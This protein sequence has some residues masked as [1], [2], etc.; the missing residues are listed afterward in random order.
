MIGLETVAAFF[1][2]A[3][4][5]TGLR[6]LRDYNP[7][8]R[9]LA[10]LLPWQFL[11]SSEPGVVL[12]KTGSF[13]ACFRLHG[14]DRASSTDGELNRLTEAASLAF[15]S[16]EPDSYTFHFD[17][18]RRPAGA[19]PGLGDFPDPLSAFL[20]SR[21]RDAYLSTGALYVTDNTL[22]VTY[23]PPPEVYQHILLRLQQ[24]V[25]RRNI[26]WRNTLE[27]FETDLEVFASK[28]GSAL[29][30]RRLTGPEMISHF[31][32]CVTGRHQVVADP[33]PGV[34]L[35][36]V[37]ATNATGGWEPVVGDQQLAL[38]SFFHLPGRAHPA[39]LDKLSDTPFPYRLS[40]RFTP[41][42][43]HTAGKIISAYTRGWSWMQKSPST[44][45]RKDSDRPD[46][47]YV[48]RHAQD[49]LQDAA[50]AV[51]ANT[52]AE[53]RFCLFTATLVLAAATRQLVDERAIALGKI[54]TDS[55]FTLRKETYNAVAAYHGTLPGEDVANSRA[56]IV[57]AQ[58]LADILPL[59]SLWPGPD[60]HPCSFF[61][62]DSPPI[63]IARTEGST[64]FR[65]FLHSGDLGHTIIV[66]P[67]GAGKST[68]LGA[69]CLGWLRYPGSRVYFFDRDH[70]ARLLAEALGCAYF[71]LGEGD[72]PL[73]FQP[74]RRLD[75]PGERATALS[76]LE[77]LFSISLPQGKLS[78][79]Q[80]GQLSDAI[81]QMARSAPALRHLNLLRGLLSDPELQQALTPFVEGPYAGYLSGSQNDTDLSVARTQVIEMRRLLDLE[82]RI[83]LPIL[84]HLLTRIEEGLDGSPTL[85]I[86]DE[87]GLALLHPAFA[88]RITQWAL[89]LRKKNACLVMA[90]QALS[91]LVDTGTFATLLQSCPSRI[92]L[93]NPDAESPSVRAVYEAC[94]LNDRQIQLVAHATRKRDY[95]IT[96]PEGARLYGLALTPTDLAFLSTL[97]GLSL[98]ETHLQMQRH[99]AEHGPNWPAHWLRT[100]GLPDE[101]ARLETFMSTEVL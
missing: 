64:P 61:P 15:S 39:M 87:A 46:D 94:G 19:Y 38:L 5:T 37:L 57:N 77:G 33:G 74:L 6:A 98:Q 2:G 81:G 44:Y 89:T 4:L 41:L 53:H 92:F 34:F 79:K 56:P 27:R 1:G 91:Q 67:P 40:V 66:G 16:V 43:G 85:L 36:Q 65:L 30:I 32:S 95:Y 69:L 45:L 96:N 50:E 42:S 23:R 90:F 48:N 22:T 47:P 20:D 54:L 70:S 97:P 7:G 25:Q 60:R 29:P 55:G 3:A 72:R 51:A 35:D 88:S 93:P 99:I 58:P 28:L 8:R 100:C 84:H 80:S 11:V 62:S 26:T 17:S 59:T 63:L 14:P 68:H 75:S 83:Y 52:R 13:S 10:E 49:M 71:D 78:P 9:G 73:G 82:P 21:R 101:A 12:N 31:Y 24:G 18:D 86:L 76:W